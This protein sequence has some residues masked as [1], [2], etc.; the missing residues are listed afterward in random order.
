VTGM[1]RSVPRNQ[2]TRV[3]HNTHWSWSSLVREYGEEH[4]LLMLQHMPGL[5]RYEERASNE[6][7]AQGATSHHE[8]EPGHWLPYLTRTDTAHGHG[9]RIGMLR[10][11][12]P[13]HLKGP[14]D[15]LA[16]PI[17]NPPSKGATK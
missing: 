2:G 15:V 13:A 17:F 7:R 8:R 11:V 6:E 12:S 9:G 1:S 16:E 10:P 5:G 14:G 3:P 4:A